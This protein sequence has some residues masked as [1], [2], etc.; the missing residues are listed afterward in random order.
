M[1][2]LNLDVEALIVQE[3]IEHQ[4]DRSKAADQR[5][6]S[7][8]LTPDLVLLLLL[9]QEL[10]LVFALLPL[11]LYYESDGMRR[12]IANNIH[13]SKGN[14]EHTAGSTT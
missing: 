4:R 6:L 11:H 8:D 10:G 12:D 7:L 3:L 2:I 13:P 9:Q 14:T 1:Q 5:G